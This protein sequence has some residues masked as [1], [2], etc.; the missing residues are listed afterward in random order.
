MAP[1]HLAPTSLG[2][3]GAEYSACGGQGPGLVWA[4]F[5]PETVWLCG[6]W[7]GIS[8]I[9]PSLWAL[10]RAAYTETRAGIL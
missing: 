5:E 3:S 4:G 8:D 9:S 6:D 2:V 1:L 10:V 7:A